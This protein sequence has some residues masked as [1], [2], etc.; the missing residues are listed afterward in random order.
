MRKPSRLLWLRCIAY[1]IACCMLSPPLQSQNRE[2]PET[3]PQP[4]AQSLAAMNVREGF[5]VTL[6]AA[7]PLVMDPVDIQWGPDGRLWVAEMAD[8]PLGV[9]GKPGG[10]I[11]FL[12]D[13]DED[14]SYETSTVFLDA[15]P[16]PTSVAPWRNGVLVTAAPDLFWAA[17][18]DGDGKADERKT[19]YTGFGQWNQQHQVNGLEWGLDNWVYVANGDSGGVVRSTKSGET[20]DIRGRDLR[21]Q[22]DTGAM[23]LQLG[24]TQ[25]GRVRDDWGNWLGCNNNA[26]WHFILADHYLRRNPHVAARATR[27]TL[28]QSL[29]V[30]PISEVYSH[31]SE[32]SPPAAGGPHIMTSGCGVMF[33]RD[34]LFGEAFERSVFFSEPVHNLVHRFQ[35]TPDG[36]SFRPARAE[37]EQRSE[38]LASRDPW[39][40]PTTVRV[41]PDGALWIADMYRRVMEHPQWIDDDFE[42]QIDLREGHR[43]GRIW[44]CAPRGAPRRTVPRLDRLETR[45]LIEALDSPSGW[46]RDLA[47]QMLLWRNDRGAIAPLE[48]LTRDATLPQGRLHALCVLDGLGALR[49]DVLAPRLTDAHAGVR[50]HAVRLAEPFIRRNEFAESILDALLALETDASP[51]VRL[52]LAYSLGESAESRAGQALARLALAN[53]S[54]PSLIDAVMSSALPHLDVLLVESMAKV[55]RGSGREFVDRLFNLAAVDGRRSTIEHVLEAL[56]SA[57]PKGFAAWQFSALADFLDRIERREELELETFA[58]LTHPVIDAAREAVANRSL[59]VA[60][61]AAAV[62]LLGRTESRR[63]DDLELLAKQFRPG[64]PP[65]VVSAAARQ[66]GSLDGE[67]VVD[68]LLRHW[69]E[70]GPSTRHAVLEALLG[71]N[72][73]TLGFLA[74]A[75]RDRTLRA[76][77]SSSRQRDLRHHPDATIRQAATKLFDAVDPD[78]AA[79]IA[80][81]RATLTGGGDVAVGRQIFERLCSN[82]HALDGLGRDVGANLTALRDTS[83]EFFL[84]HVLDPNRAVETKYLQYTAVARD[85]TVVNGIITEET[86]TSVTLQ[87]PEGDARVLLRRDLVSVTASGLSLMP[88][89]LE[90]DLSAAELDGLLEFLSRKAMPRKRFDN[91]EPALVEAAAD[92]SITLAASQAEIFGPQLLFEQRFRN[93]GYWMSPRDRAEWTFRSRKRQRYEL[94]VEWAVHERNAGDRLELRVGE[95]RLDFSVPSTGV[96]E[97]YRWRRFGELTLD[98]GQHRLLARSAGAI[99]RGALIDLRQIKLVPAGTSNEAPE[100]PVEGEE[101]GVNQPATGDGQPGA[102]PGIKTSS[103]IGETLARVGVAKIDVTPTH[104]TL[105]AGYGGRTKEH[106]G[107]DT[108]IWVRALVI[109]L[110][111]SPCALVAVDN[112][113]V[114]APVVESVTKRLEGKIA[115]ERLVVASTHTHNAPTLTGYARVVWSGRASSEAMDRTE[116]YTRF[117]AENIVKAVERALDDRKPCTLWWTQGRV[118]FGGNR[119][120]LHDSRWGGFGFQVDGPVDHSLPLLLVRDE[121]GKPKALWTSYACHCTTVG[122][123]NHVGGDWAGFANDEIEAVFAGATSLTTIGCGADVGPQPSG[124]LEIARQ[125]GVTLAKEVQR[126]VAANGDDRLRR[127]EAAKIDARMQRLRLPF[128]PLP[129]RNHWETVQGHF[130]RE[131]ARLQLERLDRGESLPTHLE[132]Y[133]V[134][135]WTFGDDLAVVFLAGEVVVDFAVRLKRELDWRR[136][137]INAWAN[138]VPGYIPSKRVLAEGG[139]EADFSQIYYDLPTRYAEGVEDVVV[140]AVKASLGETFQTPADLE[141]S[142]YH[143]HPEADPVRR[144]AAARK[145]TKDRIRAHLEGLE[146]PARQHWTRRMDLYRTQAINGFSRW[147]AAERPVSHWYSHLGIREDHHFV[148]QE[149][150]GETLTWESPKIELPATGDGPITMVFLGGLGYANQPKTDGFSLMVGDRE[151]LRFDL[152]L[153]P[154]EWRSDDGKTVLEFFPTWRSE[155]D[156]TGFFWLTLPRE[157]LVADKPLTLSVRSAGEG[158]LRWFS[159]ESYDDAAARQELFQEG[160]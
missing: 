129:D 48:A 33:Y 9:D 106:E 11:R 148:R 82:C 93:L 56:S 160:G 101:A 84:V 113:G 59:P 68:V 80:R 6:V 155:L 128:A 158:S 34:D 52:Q 5:E 133:P 35:V 97:N 109:D 46:Q 16:F 63:A 28:T 135:T 110:A 108:P 70:S 105:L 117:L 18:H 89:G 151:A 140:E 75:S 123:R 29:Q 47:H 45:G 122:G 115:R 74:A 85:G 146:P 53:L 26:S 44:R 138:D 83:R 141:P 3:R 54:Q 145:R 67:S 103:P 104:P 76:A 153:E 24:Q 98:G 23:E 71:R 39:F 156:A 86:A 40:R 149:R 144:H 102:T 150:L 15:I 38:F 57:S 60:D 147:V 132:N 73:L 107:V 87:P 143:R 12:E 116:R 99:R 58:A 112:C 120:V 13:R 43:Q 21:V 81:R 32:Y 22:P 78:R 4:P 159:L 91:N 62:T 19:L 36:L 131:H 79:V 90:Q 72:S 100:S 96:W 50:R 42:K 136:L 51:H 41:G 130:E 127:L 118:E 134:T 49:A 64:S 37:D 137:W 142:P 8:Y 111:E 114:P 119:R 139:Y 152:T 66:L 65:E 69:P 20:L 77:L 1:C 27:R 61:R 30:Y 125:H 10:R 31:W 7:E 157:V 124:S 95:E 154:A 88:E 2:R 14:G 94:W 126:L 25:Y 17:D 92:D 121:E 55:E